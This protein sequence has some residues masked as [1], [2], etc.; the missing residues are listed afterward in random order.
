MHSHYAFQ[1]PLRLWSNQIRP[2][3]VIN[4]MLFDEAVNGAAIRGEIGG[5][6]VRVSEEPEEIVG[7]FGGHVVDVNP[8]GQAERV[9]GISVQPLGV[10]LED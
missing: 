3:P 2:Q 4:G 7:E 8:N 1:Q 5:L 10:G 6:P 9:V